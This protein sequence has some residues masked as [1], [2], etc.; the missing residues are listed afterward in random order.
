V[1]SGLGVLRH[2]AEPQ[3][4]SSKQLIHSGQDMQHVHGHRAEPILSG[5]E[6]TDDEDTA[7]LNRRQGPHLHNTTC[8]AVGSIV[9]AFPLL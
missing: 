5:T 6:M 2:E 1:E 9:R 8:G 7:A 3:L 4:C